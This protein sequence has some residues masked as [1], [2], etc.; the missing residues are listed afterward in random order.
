MKHFKLLLLVS[1]C[2]CISISCQEESNFVE[3][4]V[5]QE[6]FKIEVIDVSDE[7]LSQLS[8]YLGESS[9]GRITSEYGDLDLSDAVMTYSPK[10]STTRYSF[11]I[12]LK[13]DELAFEN[14]ILAER[15]SKDESE[16]P[17]MTASIKADKNVTM[18]IVTDVKTELR[19]VNALKINYSTKKRD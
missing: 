17:Y 18:G 11:G 9:S 2:L 16:I 10:D 4:I 12:E 1:F 15:Q 6:K 19:K 8:S 3:P 14:F 13:A 5:E 7:L